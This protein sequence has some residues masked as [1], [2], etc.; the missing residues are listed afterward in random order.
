MAMRHSM[1]ELKASAMDLAKKISLL[2]NLTTSDK[3][4]K[5]IEEYYRKGLDEMELQLDMNFVGNKQRLSVFK[6]YVVDEI[7]GFSTS[8]RERLR[9]EIVDG[10]INLESMGKIKKRISETFEVARQRAEMIARTEAN[11]AYNMG[12]KDA[13][14]ESGLKLKKMVSV[15][16]DDRTSPICKRM[17]RK[18]GKRD[19]AINLDKKFIDD[20]SG[21]EFDIS[22][23]HP[24]CRSRIIY[25]QPKVE[26]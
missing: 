21:K 18:Y 20:E 1:S 14:E 3:A 9:R 13:A 4:V 25:I 10:I 15:H 17:S 24:N 11:R 2:F 16:H 6:T 22:P 19:S 5:Q 8:M 7:K 26:K 23:F 12:H